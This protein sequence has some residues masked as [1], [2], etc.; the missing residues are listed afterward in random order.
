MLDKV[1]TSLTPNYNKLKGTAV[2]LLLFALALF[3]R[4]PFFFRDYVDR[5]ESTFILIG[6]SWVDGFLPYTQ[7]WDVKP[8][9][10]FLFFA[11]IIY[12]FG[13]SFIAIRFMGTVL[14]A[15]TAFYTYKS[16]ALISTKKNGFVAAYICV[17]LL[18][19]FGSIQGVMS[20]HICMAFFM[21]AFYLLIK[22]KNPV[23][24]LNAGLLM[25]MC[26]MS[27]LNLAYAILFIG[28]FVFYDF[29]KSK[30]YWKSLRNTGLFG[31]G[32]LLIVFLTLLPYYLQNNLELWWESVFIAPL[33]YAAARRYSPMRLAPIC[34]LI[35]IFFLWSWKKK[36]LDIRKRGM[37]LIIA[38]TAGVLLS[39]I[40][41]GRINSHYLIQLFPIFIIP[42]VIVFSKISFSGKFNYRTYIF[43]LLLA[44][45]AE[46]YL[47]YFNIARNKLER[48]TFYN[49]EGFAVPE[50]INHYDL[51]TENILFLGYH[52]GYWVLGVNP[53]TKAATHPSNLC[54]DEMFSAYKNPRKTSMEELRYIM[55]ELSP[56]TIVTRKG[57]RIFDQDEVE[58]NAYM[59]Q[60]LNAH[61]SV[62]ATVD[63]A[64]IHQR[65][66]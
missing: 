4:L 15:I 54:K 39:F 45:P 60:Y 18:S 3:I 23:A 48:G 32:I 6:Q 10:T 58:E 63:N 65:L 64:E 37:L 29:T 38:A 28:L 16:G 31:I 12:F 50:Y 62:L 36:Y 34:L 30:A 35:I 13:K 49:G 17:M 7:L 61:Y 52:I 19:M 11:G 44:L 14:V 57:R 1:I 5:D 8:P 24:I 26:L 53:P 41:G 27:K 59:V 47:E 43:F 25:G 2:F 9:I 40:K 56:K 33:D 55:E 42:V 46:S 21:P 20:E 22:H 51:D 66:E